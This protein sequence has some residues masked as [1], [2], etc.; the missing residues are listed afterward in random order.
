MT[1]LSRPRSSIRRSATSAPK[2][3]PLALRDVLAALTL[4]ALT[5][6]AIVAG[7][8]TGGGIEHG[9]SYG[10]FIP[11]Y[12]YLG[13]QLRAGNI[14]S[15]NPH[16]FSGAPFAGDPESGWMY[17]PAMLLYTLFSPFRAFTLFAAFHV[18]FAGLTAYALGRVLGFTVLA[19][20][21]TGIAY[22]FS[23][24]VEA[25]SCCGVRAQVAVWLPLSILGV[26]LALRSGSWLGRA[27]W[28]SVTG[29]AISQ[30][31]SGWL[32]QGAY[33]GLLTI[34]AYL[35]FRT[36]VSPPATHRV[37]SERLITLATHSTAIL[38]LGFGLA[39]AGV[40]PRIDAVSRSNL[41]GGEYQGNAA[42]AG[43]TTGWHLMHALDRV[44]SE[45]DGRYQWYL[46]GAV[47]ALAVVAPMIARRRS[48]M[49]FFAVFAIAVFF[50]P[51]EPTLLHELLYAVLPRFEVLHQHV[52]SRS[53]VMFFLGPALM[54]GATV[55]AIARRPC[56]ASLPLRIMLLGPLLFLMAAYLLVTDRRE[57]GQ[58][59]FVGVFGVACLLGV[60][61][62]FSLPRL[63]NRR[64]AHVATAT[65]LPA[66]LALVVFWDPTGSQVLAS[67]RDNGVELPST[68]TNIR[69]LG[70]LSGPSQA[71]TFLQAQSAQA[72]QGPWRYVGTDL[73]HVG[74]QSGR[75]QGYWHDLEE[76]DVQRLLVVNQALCLNLY[77]LQGSNPVQVRR[78]VEYLA[79]L[80][81]HE[82]EYHESNVLQGG[83]SS[84]LLDA[85]SARYLIV[86]NELDPGRPDLLHLHQRFPVVYADTGVHI[87][88][89]REAFPRAW[90]VYQATQVPA[91]EALPLLTSE[92][93]DLAMTAVLESVPPDLAVPTDP[94]ADR[95]TVQSYAPD[96]IA[97]TTY[98]D[99]PGMVVL[100]E[101]YD[102]NWQ[103]YLDGDAVPVVVADH[104]LRAVAVPAGEHRLELRHESRSL[105]LGLLISALTGTL[106]TLVAVALIVRQRRGR[107][108]R[109]TAAILGL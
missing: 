66:L 35:F 32:G 83:F 1:T 2:H 96:E 45:D 75:W 37:P 90:L 3:L 63:W 104:V 61:V 60:A 93:I 40:L 94:A 9:D 86:P 55:D 108:R 21:T 5:T 20:L 25:G 85:L 24:F 23:P 80:N 87:L 77:D 69:T 58:V 4:L 8:H 47:F 19:A 7:P 97:L 34:G 107:Q 82:Q 30:M 74:A 73:A 11:M 51:F 13:E 100:S 26:E 27:G 12:S 72:G 65:L 44:L 46:A 68:P 52:S 14:P 99:A 102:P 95:V 53:L 10:F 54:A 57:V 78:Y 22:M 28:W 39:A 64:A 49:T 71:A 42:E 50:L 33:Y 59:T 79:A 92:R 105:Q 81:G 6:L 67:F 36:L 88:D 62:M 29:I 48:L 43:E 15:W 84:P 106:I 91:G 101:V 103:A 89:N 98:T 31:L 109:P 16:Q 56:G 70:C 41:A 38:L 18:A 76:R 17:L